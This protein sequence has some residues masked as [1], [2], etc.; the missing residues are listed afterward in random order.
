MRPLDWLVGFVQWVGDVALAFLLVA[1]FIG[2]PLWLYETARNYLR[3]LR[4]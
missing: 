2:V 3:E 1:L 4:R